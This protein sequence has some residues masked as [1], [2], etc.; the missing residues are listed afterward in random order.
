MAI[1]IPFLALVVV[2]VVVGAV[3]FLVSKSIGGEEKK[4]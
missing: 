3:I 2:A 4:D 1:G